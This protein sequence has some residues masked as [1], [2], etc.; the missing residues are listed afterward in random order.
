MNTIRQHIP[1]FVDTHVPYESN[2]NITEELLNIPWVKQWERDSDKKFYRWSKSEELLIAE[3]DNGN[4]WWVIGYI[5]DPK[6]VK[7]LKT[8]ESPQTNIVEKV[9]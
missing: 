8:V 3:Y 7:L 9:K 6:K 2:F 4:Y 5:K 1:N